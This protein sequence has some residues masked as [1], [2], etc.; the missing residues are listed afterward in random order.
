MILQ[1]ELDECQNCC[2]QNGHNGTCKFGFPYFPCA[3]N[4]FFLIKKMWIL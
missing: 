4:L 1:K 2:T 3:F